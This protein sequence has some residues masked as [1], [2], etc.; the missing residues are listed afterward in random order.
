[1]PRYGAEVLLPR[2]VLDGIVRGE[3]DV[4]FRSWD[5]ARVRSG[6]RLRTAIGVVAVDSVTQ[7]DPATITP[8]DARRAGYTDLADLHAALARY[9][10][11]VDR[12]VY[13]IALRYGGEDPRIALREQADLTSDD[14]ASLIERLRRMDRASRHGPWT[15]QV[16][17]LIADR[18]AV[19]AADLAAELGRERLGF[20][21]DVRK[22]KELGLTESL[23]VGYR[24]SPRGRLILS[25]LDE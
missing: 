21:A 20:K 18:P 24:L 23:D 3:I 25:K 7:V 22:L 13:R 11:G 5:R 17:R 2:E 6:T 12:P 14:V 1:M 8:D 16:L 19:R 15:A 9:T 4:A 10:R